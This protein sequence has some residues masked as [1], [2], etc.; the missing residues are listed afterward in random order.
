MAKMLNGCESLN[1]FLRNYIELLYFY[2]NFMGEKNFNQSILAPVLVMIELIHE[3][4]LSHASDYKKK[5]EE[6]KNKEVKKTNGISSPATG[7]PNNK[8]QEDDFPEEIPQLS[9]LITNKQAS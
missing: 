6:K 8:D 5:E 1:L 3:M 4:D 2:F 7:G 9:R